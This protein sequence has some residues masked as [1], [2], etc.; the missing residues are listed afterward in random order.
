MSFPSRQPHHTQKKDVEYI[1]TV[2][3]L[4]TPMAVGLEDKWTERR[5]TILRLQALEYPR[6][7]GDLIVTSPDMT[8]RFDLPREDF[9]T[10]PSVVSVF[11]FTIGA[12]AWTAVVLPSSWEF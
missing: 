2:Q 12:S 4:A 8:G 1:E 3:R 11:S 9:F 7:R 5:L 6:L 10:R